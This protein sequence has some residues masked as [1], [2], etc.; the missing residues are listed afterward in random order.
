MAE[1]EPR[2]LEPKGDAPKGE[3]GKD[4]KDGKKKGPDP[5]EKKE[6]KKNDKRTAVLVILTAAGVLIAWMTLRKNPG[7][8]QAAA[9]TTT[10]AGSSANNP[11]NYPTSNGDVAGFGVGQTAGFDPNAYMG[12]QQQLDQ[13]TNQISK[14]SGTAGA[15]STGGVTVNINNPPTGG[16]PGSPHSGTN[17]NPHPLAGISA[18]AILPKGMSVKQ[19]AASVKVPVSSVFKRGNH[20]YTYASRGN[21]SE[22][23]TAQGVLGKGETPA[24]WA[25]RA[26]VPVSSVQTGPGGHVWTYAKH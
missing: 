16:V 24:Q 20:V 15:T 21:P 7:N 18:Q 25:A 11:L 3:D 12:L 22:G 10:P 13:L 14:L 9:S 2:E 17:A 19:W 23:V 5:F 26:H 4:G 8:N 1:E 6:G